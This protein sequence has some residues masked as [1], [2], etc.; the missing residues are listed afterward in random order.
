M[1]GVLGAIRRRSGE[2]ELAL[3]SA[4]RTRPFALVRGSWLVV[5]TALIVVGLATPVPA[6]HRYLTKVTLVRGEPA[7]RGA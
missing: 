1:R 4:R 6:K 7:N 3:Y 2:W 5:Q